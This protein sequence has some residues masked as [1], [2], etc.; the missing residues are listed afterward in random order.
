[1]P[2]MDEY[3]QAVQENVC[4]RCVDSDGTG[5]CRMGTGQCCNIRGHLPKVVDVVNGTYSSTMDPY[6][7]QLRAV[8]CSQCEHQ[9]THGVC[10][11]R[12]EVDC[13]LDRYFPLVVQVI[14]NVGFRARLREA[15]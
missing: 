11:R 1:M 6:V 14:E 8:V 13:A 2:T 10:S 9:D 15:G 12:D 5:E 4:P 3:W 7:E